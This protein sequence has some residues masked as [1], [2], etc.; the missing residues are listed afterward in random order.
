MKYNDADESSTVVNIPLR[1]A[2]YIYKGLA[3]EPEMLLTIISSGGETSTGIRAS[4]NI[5][6]NF[7]LKGI[8]VPFV[9]AGAGYGNGLEFLGYTTD[10]ETGITSLQFGAGVKI[11]M[12]KVAA[13]RLEYR[14]LSYS[15]KKEYS[16]SEWGWTYSYTEDYGRNDHKVMVGI[17]IFL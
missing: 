1:L 4:G 8:V 5:C 6:Y 13:I 12:N 9:L 11:L 2:Y 15:G 17:S 7:D 10:L 3:I 14:F 16:Y